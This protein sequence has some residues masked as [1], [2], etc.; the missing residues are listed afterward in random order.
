MVTASCRG[1]LLLL[2]SIPCRKLTAAVHYINILYYFII[3]YIP[4]PPPSFQIFSRNVAILLPYTSIITAIIIVII[5][6]IVLYMR[7][8]QR[9][10]STTSF[11]YNIITL[12]ARFVASKS[13]TLR[14]NA[15]RPVCCYS[16]VDVYIIYS[17][18]LYNNMSYMGT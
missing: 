15:R 4:S 7:L 10:R 14:M 16:P 17:D 18:I 1:A 3:L 11:L 6:M 13:I 12:F 9:K 2:S 5:N 8:I